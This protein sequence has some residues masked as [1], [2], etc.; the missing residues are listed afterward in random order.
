MKEQSER[1]KCKQWDTDKFLLENRILASKPMSPSEAATALGISAALVLR[2]EVGILARIGIYA[3]QTHRWGV[4]DVV[5]QLQEIE[6]RHCSKAGGR[7]KG[8]AYRWEPAPK[9]EEPGKVYAGLLY[10]KDEPEL[11]AFLRANPRASVS[12][13]AEVIAKMSGG[14]RPG[15]SS[16]SWYL[17]KL[18][19]QRV[20]TEAPDAH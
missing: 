10:P 14:R 7:A 18:G 6:D 3:V 8:L 4:S 1:D 17:R 11:V 19:F 20:R 13:V 9:S 15:P 5:K 2:R 16:V 12:T